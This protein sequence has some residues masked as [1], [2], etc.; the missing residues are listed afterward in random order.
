MANHIGQ[1]TTGSFDTWPSQRMVPMPWPMRSFAPWG[2]GDVSTPIQQS[3][4]VLAE[5]HASTE[6]IAQYV[7]QPTEV[8]NLIKP[9]IGTVRLTAYD[10]EHRPTS[11]YVPNGSKVYVD[12]VLTA[13]IG[14]VGFAQF[15]MHANDPH[16]ITVEMVDPYWG[17][18]YVSTAST[19]QTVDL[20]GIIDVVV[21]V[22]RAQ[23]EPWVYDINV[24][25]KIGSGAY[26]PLPADVYVD[27]VLIGT[28]DGSGNAQ[29]R[30]LDAN[31]HSYVVIVKDSNIQEG[32][33]YRVHAA[34]TYGN[35]SATA[36]FLG[37]PPRFDFKSELQ[38]IYDFS[39]SPTTRLLDLVQTGSFF[40]YEPL[41]ITPVY[42]GVFTQVDYTIQS[43][44]GIDTHT[45]TVA[46]F[47]WTWIPDST[48]TPDTIS[49]TA[50]F[51]D[52]TG[53]T[54][55]YSENFLIHSRHQH[56]VTA[57]NAS[58]NHV[59]PVPISGA[60]V[61]VDGMQ[62]GT[63]DVSG[64][65]TIS[66]D[67]DN[68]HTVRVTSDNQEGSNPDTKSVEYTFASVFDVVSTHDY[69]FSWTVQNRPPVVTIQDNGLAAKGRSYILEADAQDPDGN[70]SRVSFYINN[71]FVGSKV[72]AP[73]A[74][75]WTPNAVG[76]YALTAVAVDE[77][78]ATGSDFST[79]HVSLAPEITTNA[80]NV[81][82]IGTDNEV[83]ARIVS[84]LGEPTVSMSWDS[85]SLAFTGPVQV[86]ANTYEY[87]FNLRS[88]V[89][90]HIDLVIS[91]TSVEGLTTVYTKNIFVASSY[92]PQVIVTTKLSA[93]EYDAPIPVS[94]DILVDDVPVG[95]TNG[96]DGK[97]IISLPDDGPHK[98]TGHYVPDDLFV[99][100]IFRGDYGT[101]TTLQ[102]FIF[103]KPVIA[104]E[105]QPEVKEPP[106]PYSGICHI[107]PM[108]GSEK[109]SYL[110]ILYG[111]E[112]TRGITP[113][114]FWDMRSLP[115]PF[116]PRNPTVFK[117]IIE[118]EGVGSLFRLKIL[119]ENPTQI[120]TTDTFDFVA[121]STEHTISLYLGQGLNVF[122]IYAF[123]NGGF[124]K[125]GSVSFTAS[126]FATILYT[127]AT[128]IT[129][130][131]WSPFNQV[132]VDIYSESSTLLASPLIDFDAELP[133]S[134]N[135]SRSAR[136]RV[137]SAMV[138]QPTS[139]HAV[140]TVAGSLFQQ[141]PILCKPAYH[142]DLDI[143]LSWLR[144]LPSQSQVANTVEMHVW[145]NDPEMARWASLPRYLESSG[146][147]LS[148]GMAVTSSQF[149][150]SAEWSS[151]LK[152]WNPEHPE[153]QES[154]WELTIESE[155]SYE[156]YPHTR[157][158]SKIL[159]PGLWDNGASPYF[160]TG[161]LW[162]SQ[163]TWD[164]G[165][166]SGDIVLDGFV[167]TR[168]TG[169]K[170]WNMMPEVGVSPLDRCVETLTISNT[171]TTNSF[172]LE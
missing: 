68:T 23:Y 168:I 42:T 82:V 123:D 130:F 134:T 32:E 20:D 166:A 127:Y 74:I 111:S 146:Q 149:G 52:D 24:S 26:G 98:I 27:G 157:P 6:M 43:S 117:V 66:F 140:Q 58:L 19:T 45:S 55:T 104:E 15:D 21:N 170:A 112:T 38:Y 33:T 81:M 48:S 99:W 164:S 4:G 78:G 144:E 88:D 49:I 35:S 91:A 65:Y 108:F 40:N 118:E 85:Q 159:F 129:K 167:G 113:G 14:N 75:T 100:T 133:E 73:Y 172:T 151:T 9:L 165:D 158:L 128:L 28:T 101:V 125:I 153:Q 62:V 12:G 71:V 54:G 126:N 138:N 11:T 31:E 162:D 2:Y 154:W 132:S 8:R 76:S 51:T 161:N 16:E 39:I 106:K 87:V 169:E 25:S 29:V 120:P 136:Q 102:E 63:T 163:R 46:P 37:T 44:N 3:V 150:E 148:H 110:R 18:P 5:Q 97:L 34:C 115:L 152:T 59:T 50:V 86:A 143:N 94:A 116:R 141:T 67:D 57:L 36:I 93:P 47:D 131:L 114:R 60:R 107:E 147:L 171:Y 10:V 77:F 109:D 83:T 84:I 156:L 79:I 89:P 135:L 1:L 142:A 70:V 64:N 119:R 90:K 121:E 41:V 22:P 61:Y 137:V 160:D 103:S 92:L 72:L 80:Q 95:Y 13:T 122:D 96:V 30:A 155:S 69:V 139:T 56:V 105:I 124:V 53:S 7:G 145:Q 17:M